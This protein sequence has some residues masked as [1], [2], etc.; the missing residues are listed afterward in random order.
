MSGSRLVLTKDERRALKHSGGMDVLRPIENDCSRFRDIVPARA[1]VDLSGFA[2]GDAVLKVPDKHKD[3]EW[4]SLPTNDTA[5][6]IWCPYGYSG[7]TRYKGVSIVEVS[8]AYH[9]G[10]FWRITLR[11][12]A[13]Q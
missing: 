1:W 13:K 2:T 4:E 3:D 7:T 5:R 8:V 11:K 9:G 6:R 12:E 10:W